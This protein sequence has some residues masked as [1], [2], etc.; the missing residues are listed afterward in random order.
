MSL[1][2][3]EFLEAFIYF[4]NNNDARSVG[5]DEL[6]CCVRDPAIEYKRKGYFHKEFG[7]DVQKLEWSICSFNSKKTLKPQYFITF[8]IYIYEIYY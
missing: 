1:R 2:D 8:L 5:N 3:I 7:G 6:S 4:L